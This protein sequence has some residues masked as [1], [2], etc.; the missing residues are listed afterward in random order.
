MPGDGQVRLSVLF[1]A[2]FLTGCHGSRR[3]EAQKLQE[4]VR[5]Y[6]QIEGRTPTAEELD[7]EYKGVAYARYSDGEYRI[8]Y[9]GGIL[10]TCIWKSTY[11]CEPIES[12]CWY[13]E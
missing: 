1:L 12:D 2:V 6:I 3:A 11:D 4:D 5:A 9:D 7:G 10:S 13:C 8:S